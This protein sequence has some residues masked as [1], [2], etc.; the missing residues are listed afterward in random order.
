MGTTLRRPR[1]SFSVKG[2]AAADI[3]SPDATPAVRMAIP[4]EEV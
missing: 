3:R 4:R 2:V 1:I